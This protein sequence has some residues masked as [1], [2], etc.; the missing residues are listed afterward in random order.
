VR[1]EAIAHKYPWV[2][3]GSFFSLGVKYKFEPLQ[4]DIGVGVSTVGVR[5][6]PPRSGVRY[7]VGSVS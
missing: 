3:V 7:P 5:I 1:P 2:S 4:A 6:V